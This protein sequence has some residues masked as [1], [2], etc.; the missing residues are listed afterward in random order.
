VV[1]LVLAGRIKFKPTKLINLY[2]IFL[3][4]FLIFLSLIIFIGFWL[5][6]VIN[7]WTLVLAFFIYVLCLAL[8]FFYKRSGKDKLLCLCLFAGVT[9]LFFMVGTT[10]FGHTYDT[11]YDGVSYHETAV[12]ALA[13]GW[14]PVYKPNFPLKTPKL[15]STNLDQGSPKVI[16][17]IDASVYNLTDNLDSATFI[18][19]MIGIVAFIFV[20][21]GLGALGLQNRMSL[22]IAS[23]AV[24]NPLFIDQIYSFRE[25]SLSY[26]LLL[27]GLASLIQINKSR[28][29]YIYYMCLVSSLILLAGSKFSNLYIFISLILLGTYI[30]WHK[31]LYLNRKLQ[32]ISIGTL[33]VGFIVLFNPFFTNTFYYHSIKYPYN[34]T[35]YANSL[36]QSGVPT[37]IRY[38]PK[39]KLLFYGIFSSSDVRNANNKSS[40]AKLKIPFTFTEKELS[41]NSLDLSKLV[42]GYG[43]LFSGIF[44]LSVIAYI[45]LIIESK[46]KSY[47]SLLNWTSIC[48]VL[49]LVSCL[50]SPIPNYSRYNSQLYLFPI[51]IVVA[52]SLINSERRLMNK[53]LS[54]LILFCLVLNFCLDFF[55]S[56]YMQ[57]S[58]FN[59]I[60]S[61]L[62][63]LKNSHKTYK[64]YSELF[65]PSYIELRQNDVNINV[66]DKPLNCHNELYLEFP[67]A[68]QLCPIN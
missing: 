48:L 21:E 62:A 16:W 45:Y 18:N 42:G 66:T 14:N 32:I 6:L 19:L 65:Y 34:Q 31:K 60:N 12:I 27:I 54:V 22:I 53:L 30:G 58:N 46:S 13:N 56:T 20:Y 8:Y 39:L 52:L 24:L 47:K 17:S 29:K 38:D 61:Q 57:Q 63:L 33:I 11:S 26:N 5:D 10:Y 43:V 36:R 37:N 2:A 59:K 64:V 44:V 23:V 9:T 25:D 40:Y 28:H 50:L 67:R 41:N 3:L 1:L 55:P 51:I 35:V 68:T 4:L 7:S 49:L 15:S